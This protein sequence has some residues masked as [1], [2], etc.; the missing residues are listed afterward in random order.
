MESKSNSTAAKQVDGGAAVAAPQEP[1]RSVAIASSGIRTD[2]QAGEFLS[3]LIGDLMT[4][5]IPVRIGTASIN[6]LGKMLKL[7]ELRQKYGDPEKARSL[8]L[9]ASSREE[10]IKARRQSLLAQLADLDASGKV[11]DGSTAGSR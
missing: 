6:A 3:A 5:A 4:Q 10:S 2:Q 11:V 1:P 8:E 7:V 9:V